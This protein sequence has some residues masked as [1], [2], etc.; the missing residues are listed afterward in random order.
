[1]DI[2]KLRKNSLFVGRAATAIYLILHT[3]MKEKE[4]ILPSNICYAAVYPIIYSDNIPVFVDVDR[5]TGNA[6]FE[7]IIK[8]VN[9]NTG[10][11]IFPY[12]YGNVSKDIIELKKY[13]KINNII[14]IE[15]CAS[16]MGAKIDNYDGGTIGDY[17]V[18]STGHAKIVDVGNGGILVTDNNIDDIIK[19]Y[20]R[21]NLYND[22]INYKLEKFSKEY[23]QL[24]NNGNDQKIKEFFNKDYRELFLYKI[25]ETII[26]KMKKEIANI[27]NIRKERIEKYQMFLKML[28]KSNEYELLDFKKGSIPWR[29]TLLV[30]NEEHR[31]ELI[32][33]LLDNKLFVSDWYPCI[34]KSFSN[35]I[36][37]NSDYMENKILNFSLT[38]NENNI[39]KICEIMNN[40]FRRS[41]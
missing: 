39:L 35:D 37:S 8:K 6:L 3:L 34:G 29:F 15:D 26:D 23:R 2:T 27:E 31:K 18:F 11:I 19:E 20:N 21:L 30:N 13:C 17:A 36:Y 12:M 22:E 5:K 9:K 1:M 7:E 33:I 4:I 10:A 28:D 41:K 38:D 24:R 32:K 16:A 14:L 25:N 40:Y